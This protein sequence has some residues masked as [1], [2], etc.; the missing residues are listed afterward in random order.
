MKIENSPLAL[1]FVATLAY[2][3]ASCGDSGTSDELTSSS[4]GPSGSGSEGD[5]GGCHDVSMDDPDSGAFEFLACGFELPC[6]EVEY[7]SNS[8]VCG[9]DVVYDPAAGACVIDAL[10]D[11]TQGEYR[12]RDCPGG[13]SSGIVLLQVLGDD[14]VVWRTAEFDDAPTGWRETWRTLPDA[15]HFEGCSVDTVENLLACTRAILE[16]DCLGGTP[17]CPEG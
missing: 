1:V 3:S 6:P 14:S 5:G 10:R 16:E 13:Q 11:G 7:M 4:E 2:G 8:D 12:I 9:M 15:A 17:S